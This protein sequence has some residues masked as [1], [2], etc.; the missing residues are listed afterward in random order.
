MQPATEEPA[1][2]APGLDDGGGYVGWLLAL[3]LSFRAR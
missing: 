3:L 2:A 1:H